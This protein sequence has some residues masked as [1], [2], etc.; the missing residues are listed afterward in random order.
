MLGYLRDP[1]WMRNMITADTIDTTPV[2]MDE[3]RTAGA[4]L[5]DRLRAIRKQ[6]K[7]TLADL[8]DQTGLAISTLSKVE[9]NKISLTYEKLASLASGLELDLADLLTPNSL[10]MVVGHSTITRRGEGRH[11]ETANYGHEYLCV[12]LAG[13][14]MVPLVSRIKARSL[15]EF[16]PLIAHPGEEFVYALEGSIDIHVEGSG[17]VRL[18]PGDS[19][20]F[21]PRLGHALISVGH[22]DAFVLSVISPPL[23]V[24]TRRSES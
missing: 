7:W 21:D 19:F 14:R 10:G 4:L 20:Y 8:R 16:G 3:P 17:P 13:R 5:G 2:K 18:R 6:R 12:D 9:N 15:D 11:H 24:A 22:G 23:Y 1:F